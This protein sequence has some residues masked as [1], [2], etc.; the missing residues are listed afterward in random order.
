VEIEPVD[1]VPADV[2][3]AQEVFSYFFDQKMMDPSHL[4]NI[5]IRSG[6]L[7]GKR[8]I[9][10]NLLSDDFIYCC[11]KYWIATHKSQGIDIKSNGI[12]LNECTQ[13]KHFNE[14]LTHGSVGRKK[15]KWFVSALNVEGCHFVI[16]AA[17]Y[18][19]GVMMYLDPMVPQQIKLND[20]QLQNFNDNLMENYKQVHTGVKGFIETS[21]LIKNSAETASSGQIEAA[22][23]VSITMQSRRARHL[24]CACWVVYC[25]MLLLDNSNDE[26]MVNM[27]AKLDKLEGTRSFRYPLAQAFDEQQ[28]TRGVRLGSS[29]SS[30]CS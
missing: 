19:M 1:D 8:V 2:G 30:S 9:G 6:L 4:K 14:Y 21:R 17:S 28:N 16:A 25:L 7:Q 29:A 26:N 10:H 13:L 24:N 22:A 27:L 5:T 20:S 18:S 23:I 3:I 15:P 12:L 11:L